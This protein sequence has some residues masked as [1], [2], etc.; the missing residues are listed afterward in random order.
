MAV[1]FL[2]IFVLFLLAVLEGTAQEIRMENG[3]FVV[4]PWN[5]AATFEVFAGPGDVPP[6]MG[7]QEAAGGRLVFT[8]RFPLAPEMTVRAVLRDPGKGEREVRF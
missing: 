7:S 5:P 8:P 6:L 1:R 4:S 3:K 2:S